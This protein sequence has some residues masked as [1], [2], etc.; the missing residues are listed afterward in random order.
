AGRIHA[1]QV[2]LTG[3][4]PGDLDPYQMVLAGV[5]QYMIG[6]TDWSVTALHN[7][8]IMQLQSNGDYWPV[9]YDFDFS[10]AV[11]ARYAI[12][13]ERLHIRNVRQRLYR[14]YCVKDPEAYPKVYAQFNAK[15]DSI[16]ALYRDPLGK[17]LKPD[18]VKETLEYFDDF[19]KVINDP[20]S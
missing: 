3:A 19:Y 6:N 11:N 10:G 13:D 12:P 14:G 18:V 15:K 9:I 17:L 4:G 20:R 16:Y 1:K 7:V 5:F 8:E 2:K